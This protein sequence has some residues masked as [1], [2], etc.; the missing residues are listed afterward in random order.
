MLQNSSFTDGR[1]IFSRSSLS[2]YGV[3]Y[4]SPAPVFTDTA[5]HWARADI[6]FV[7]SRGLIMGM[8]NG[9]VRMENEDEEYNSQFSS[10][11]SQFFPEREITRAD[12]LM[13]LGRLA[14]A[15]VSGFTRSSFTDVANTN[16]AMPYI[17]WAT[18]NGIANGVNNNRFA[19]NDVITREQMAVM[20]VNFAEATGYNLPISRQAVTFADNGRIN[21]WASD[22]V[23]SIQQTGIMAGRDNNRFGPQGRSGQLRKISPP[24]GFDPRTVQ[25]V[26]SRYTDYATRPK[27]TEIITI[28]R[29]VQYNITA[30]T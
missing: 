27:F 5:D 22:A 24:T 10:F 8:E 19:T 15:D 9:E 23:R 13:A 16:P 21:L 29:I 4:Q 30:I 11:N 12:F 3:G 17:E 20:M 7:A 28:F 18:E 14:G 1:V 26:D 2:L 25:P 6:D